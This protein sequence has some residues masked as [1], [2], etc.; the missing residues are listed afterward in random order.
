MTQEEKKE[1][2]REI[3]KLE[4]DLQDYL[5]VFPFLGVLEK[6]KERVINQYLDDILNRKKRLENE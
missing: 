6:E 5:R 4:K 1:L 2:E 3:E